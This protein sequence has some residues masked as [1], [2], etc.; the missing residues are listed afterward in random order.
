[1]QS[2]FRQVRTW[3]AKSAPRSDDGSLSIYGFTYAD[4]RTI[5]NFLVISLRDRYLG[6]RLGLIWAIL[7]PLLLFI[8]FTIVFGFVFKVRLPGA[9][10]TLGYAIWLIS[11]FGPWMAMSEALITSASS[12][13]AAAGLIKNVAFKN[14]IL[15]IVAALTSIVTL[16]V[17][18]VFLTIL[19]MIDGRPP[20]WHFLYLIPSTIVMYMT[21]I[22]VAPILATLS[23]FM[24]DIV[25][26]LPTLL[27]VVMFTTP[28]L[29][30][31]SAVP[32]VLAKVAAFNPIYIMAESFRAPLIDRQAPD[33]VS[34][35]ILAVVSL[36][37]AHFS[38]GLYRRAKGQFEAYV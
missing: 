6:S 13:I 30:P 34:L 38:F 18:F 29:Y 25:Q 2:Q 3:L 10:T 5:R 7:N 17:S 8:V 19:M 33:F 32:W 31:L 26:V 24:R 4:L 36:I 16:T 23:V 1:M 37:L 11:G 12:V 20:S 22:S 9:E 28:I 35:G 27:Q 21:L 15:P 14:E